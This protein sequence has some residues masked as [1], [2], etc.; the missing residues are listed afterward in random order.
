[1]K[2]VGGKSSQVIV[3]AA[4]EIDNLHVVMALLKCHLK[5][6]LSILNISK[7]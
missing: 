6:K 5:I 4:V 2:A 7:T 3:S 1:M